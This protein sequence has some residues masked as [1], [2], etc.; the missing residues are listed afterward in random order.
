M[1]RA[2]EVRAASMAATAKTK[3][4]LYMKASKEI[5][6]AAKTGDSDPKNNLALRAVLEK[7]KGQSIPRDVIK[8]AIEKSQG[9]D[10]AVYFENRYEG[11]GPGGTMFIVDTLADNEKRAFALVRAIFNHKGGKIGN[12]G[13]VAYNFKKCGEIEFDGDNVDEITEM[14]IL[15]DVDVKDVSAEDNIVTVLTSTDDFH[16]AED[17]LKEN[18]IEDFLTD[19]VTLIPDLKVDVTG[20]DVRK[21][22]NFYD[23]L[24]EIEDVQTIYTNANII[25]DEEKE[26]EK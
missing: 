13:T 24:D 12:S 2:H 11:F 6:M 18:G 23:A 25:E 21:Y 5:Y 19:E 16:K 1:G 20:D 3:S 17:V 8:R 9:T 15:G 22:R 26:E 10:S 4:A 14:L 7:F